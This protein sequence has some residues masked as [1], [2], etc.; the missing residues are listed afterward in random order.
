L[1]A[2]SVF[3]ALKR[4]LADPGLFGQFRL[5][6]ALPDPFPGQAQADGVQVY[7]F[8]FHEVL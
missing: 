8:R 7:L 6:Q 3:Q 2:V 4:A 5:G 1:H